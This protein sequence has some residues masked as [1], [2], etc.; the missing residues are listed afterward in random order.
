MGLGPTQ[1]ENARGFFGVCVC[2]CVCGFRAT[3]QIVLDNPWV[4]G[5]QE[6]GGWPNWA[7][8]IFV[9]WPQA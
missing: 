8:E 3:L 1:L 4:H 9:E 2:V 7:L 6:S 5:P